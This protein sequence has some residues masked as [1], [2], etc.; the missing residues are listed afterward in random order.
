M[1]LKRNIAV[2]VACA[3]LV[4]LGVAMVCGGCGTETPEWSALTTR[5]ASTAIPEGTVQVADR[6]DEEFTVGTKPEEEQTTPSTAPTE[7]TEPS[8]DESGY[9]T[10][11]SY[12]ALGGEKQ[13]EY[14]YTF[15]KPNGDLDLK[16]FND[17][18]NAAKEAYDAAHPKET[19][20]PDGN[21]D[22]SNP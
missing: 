2:A 4:C 11:E 12:M 8:Y 19:I 13:M 9:M 6:G 10:Y 3:L 21:I 20:G 17:W 7:A 15:K 18:Y 16:A 5:P 14:M 1:K 22:L